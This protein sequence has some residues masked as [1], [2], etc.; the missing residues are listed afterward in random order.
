[1]INDE[2]NNYHYFATKDWKELNSLGWLQ[3]KK[4]Q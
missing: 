2:V 3:V 1:M 4:K